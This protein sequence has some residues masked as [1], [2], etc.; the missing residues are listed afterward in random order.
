MLGTNIAKLADRIAD[1]AQEVFEG[2]RG[3]LHL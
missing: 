2:Q 3:R 1:R